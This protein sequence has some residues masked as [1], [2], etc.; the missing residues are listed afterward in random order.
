MVFEQGGIYVAPSCYW[1]QWSHKKELHLVALC[2]KQ[3]GT[4]GLS[5]PDV[6]NFKRILKAMFM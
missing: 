4:E 1:R 2:D 5:N 3:R 6:Y